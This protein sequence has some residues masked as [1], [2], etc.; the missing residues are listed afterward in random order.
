VLLVS[1]VIELLA[2]RG[3]GALDADAWGHAMPAGSGTGS[4]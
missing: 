3:D 2:E 4:P 1:V